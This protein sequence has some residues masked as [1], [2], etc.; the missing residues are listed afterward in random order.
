MSARI[1]NV[2][3]VLVLAALSF[4][5]V[6]NSMTKPLG[7]DEHMYCTGGVLLA[8][9]RMIYRDFS[10]VAQLPY[11]A[12]LCAV[13]FK[14]LGTTYYLL[15]GRL[16]SSFSDIIVVVCIVGIYR[17]VFGS[18][19]ISG[20]LLALAAAVLYVF[21]PSVDYANGYAW[22]N[23]VVI[24]CVV[25]AFWLFVSIDFGRKSGYWL[26]GAVGV[27]LGFATCMRITT[28]LVQ[29][30]FFVVL[31]S[32][33]AESLR[34]KA[35]AVLPFLAG[36]VIV[37]VWVLWTMLLAPR[38]FF[39]DVFRIHMLNSKWLHQIGM[40]HNKFNLTYSSITAQGYFVLIVIG[41]C[42]LVALLWQRHK[43]V[44]ANK[45]NLVLAVLLPAAFFVIALGLPTI[46]KQYLAM[47]VPFLIIGFAFGLRYL[48]ELN[49]KEKL[50]R[51]F[52][53]AV[54][55]VAVCV[56]VA[57]NSYPIV[58]KRIPKFF[59]VKNWTAIELHRISEDIAERTK[60]P[61]RILTLAPLYALEGG[62]D[63]YTELSAGSFVYRIGDLLTPAELQT[64]KATGPKALKELLE[65]CPPSA[66]IL[67]VEFKSFEESLFQTAV[68]P[69]QEIWEKKVYTDAG[70]TVY[71]RR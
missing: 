52:K 67:G 38:A 47:P 1:I 42:L 20:T 8:Q 16:L 23:D 40:V 63:I 34:Q 69:N 68:A 3:V 56:F 15:V 45:R 28:A 53:I 64:V 60:Q 17:H 43:V 71:F 25:L 41:L 66:V 48:R 49:G 33:P 9:G 61:K 30:L 31:L 7:R 24:A 29:L 14:I 11:H 46:W 19:R 6:A 37:S 58:L 55:L 54:A 51:Q 12:L 57:V 27:L 4:G 39:L 32:Q 22:N 18:F 2:V 5:I 10:Y 50:S 59:E 26:T 62:S 35:K 65:R 21:N 44:V 70:P 36:T 13:L